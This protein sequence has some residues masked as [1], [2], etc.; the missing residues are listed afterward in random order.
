M[1][2]DKV[3]KRKNEFCNKNFKAHADLWEHC[4]KASKGKLE[5]QSDFESVARGH[6]TIM[7]KGSRGTP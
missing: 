5:A 7:L 6:P 3:L 4:G 1:K 2:Y